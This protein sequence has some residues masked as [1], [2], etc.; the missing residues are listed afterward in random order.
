MG[1]TFRGDDRE[2]KIDSYRRSRQERKG[3]RT[4]A[5]EEGGQ[6]R[7]DDHRRRKDYDAY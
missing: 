3:K 5:K 2:R 6:E 1:R 4:L 7:K